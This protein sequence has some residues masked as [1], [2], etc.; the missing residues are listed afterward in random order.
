[1]KPVNLAPKITLTITKCNT[2]I[3]ETK[4]E[5]KIL[6]PAVFTGGEHTMLKR[7]KIP[8]IRE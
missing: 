7:I 1:M 8:L 6:N 3:N 2:Y 5:K 4:E